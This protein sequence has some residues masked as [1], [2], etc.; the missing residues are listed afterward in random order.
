MDKQL[1]ILHFCID[2]DKKRHG[3]GFNNHVPS[4]WDKAAEDEK[5]CTDQDYLADGTW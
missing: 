1:P 5:S 3:H 4:A 2:V